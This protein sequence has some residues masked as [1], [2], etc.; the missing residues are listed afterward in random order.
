[1]H[2]PLT[3]DQLRE[4]VATDAID[5]VVVA[6]PDMQGRLVGKRLDA[7]YFLNDAIDSGVGA[8]AY[9]ITRDID[10]QIVDGF[11]IAGWADGLSDFEL[12][13]DLSTLRRLPWMP[14]TALVI[15]DACWIGGERSRSPPARSCAANWP[16]WL[17]A[18]GKRWW[19]PS[20]NSCCSTRAMSRRTRLTT[21]TCG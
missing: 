21:T 10:M 14:G 5:T 11:D 20:W 19:P 16:D 12:A 9:L 17:S 8:C 1:M 7:N 2:P 13:P 15:A 4:E 6:M 3:L 18:V